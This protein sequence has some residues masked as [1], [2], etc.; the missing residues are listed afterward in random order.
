MK[1]QILSKFSCHNRGH[2][3]LNPGHLKWDINR[4]DYM[5]RFVDKIPFV[6]KK[7]RILRELKKKLI[8]DCFC[9]KLA[10][11]FSQ[12]FQ[13][14]R[15]GNMVNVRFFLCVWWGGGGANDC[16]ML[17]FSCEG[18]IFETIINVFF[19]FFYVFLFFLSF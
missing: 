13:K 16:E 1:Q 15:I 9:F 7:L 12:L 5:T 10:T 2:G 4:K 14:L 18:V 17:K 8:K 6:N 3:D 19:Y 11:A